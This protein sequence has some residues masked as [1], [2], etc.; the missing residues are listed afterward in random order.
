[1]LL[2]CPVCGSREEDEFVYGGDATILRPTHPQEL[3]DKDWTDFVYIRTNP[4]G[5]HRE[6]WFHRFG[7]RRWLTVER[8]TVTHKIGA[9]RLSAASGDGEAR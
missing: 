3:S 4:K 1:M 5:A 6:F 7:C 2:H 8:D 9:I